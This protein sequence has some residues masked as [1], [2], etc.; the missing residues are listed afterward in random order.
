MAKLELR[1][2]G[3]NGYSKVVQEDYVSG[4]KFL[5]YLKFLD[6]MAELQD[7]LSPVEFLVRKIEF[8][9]SLFTT[10]K[11]KPKDIIEGVNSWELVETVDRLLEVA[12]GAKGDDPKPDDYLLEKV[13]SV[14]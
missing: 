13:E 2:Q 8:L 6:E 1:L 3:K 10:E 14:S 9:A 7:S 4:Q 5:D 12:M 11:V